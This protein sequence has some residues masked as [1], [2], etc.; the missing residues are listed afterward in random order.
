MKAQDREEKEL[1]RRERDVQK[2]IEDGKIRE[3]KYNKKYKKVGDG[4]MRT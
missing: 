2:Q 3:V 1:M 4:K